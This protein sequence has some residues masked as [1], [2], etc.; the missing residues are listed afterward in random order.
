MAYEVVALGLFRRNTML[1]APDAVKFLFVLVTV[2]GTTVACG[3][4][5]PKDRPNPF[6]V[7][8]VYDVNAVSLNCAD[9]NRCT[10]S[11]GIILTIHV[12]TKSYRYY[13]T[14][15]TSVSRCTG[16]LYSPTQVLTAGHC[17][18]GIGTGRSFFKTVATAGMPSR[19]FE[20]KGVAKSYYSE[21]NSFSSDYATL[22]L[23]TP[24]NGYKYVRAAGFIS[25]SLNEVTA[26]V[27]NQPSDDSKVFQLDNVDCEVDAETLPLHVG[28]YPSVWGTKKCKLV[29]GN[30]GGPG[31][32]ER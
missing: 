10:N 11:L 9:G 14:T 15:T 27:V 1:R 28:E 20:I 6:V 25:P 22:E 16:A 7:S 18:Q 23:K 30:S 24:A 29:G 21:A 31:F 12:E 5:P 32:R 3:K 8:G 13:K 4:S 2:L 17:T 19:I 26:L